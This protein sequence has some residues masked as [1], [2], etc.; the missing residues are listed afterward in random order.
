MGATMRAWTNG[1]SLGKR[2]K[3]IGL[4]LSDRDIKDEG[5]KDM[6]SNAFDGKRNRATV[7]RGYSLIQLLVVMLLV[8]ILAMVDIRPSERY[9]RIAFRRPCCKMSF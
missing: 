3:R 9:L 4:L 1:A 2:D 7:Q 6:Y 8:S 5:N